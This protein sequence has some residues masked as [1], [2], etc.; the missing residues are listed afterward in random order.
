MVFIGQKPIF[1][2]IADYIL[3]NILTGVIA[4]NERIPSVRDMAQEIEVNPNTV[5]RAYSFLSDEGIIQNQRGIGYFVSKDALANTRRIRIKEFMEEQLPQ[6][7]EN[8]KILN[9]SME[10]I[11]KQYKLIVD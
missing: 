1:L 2:Q 3:T 10:D 9:I 11:E 4:P 5:A 8:M 6:I 7:F